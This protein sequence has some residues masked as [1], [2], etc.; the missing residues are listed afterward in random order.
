MV[1]CGSPGTDLVISRSFFLLSHDDEGEAEG[2]WAGSIDCA[3]TAFRPAS[4]HASPV[5]NGAPICRFVGLGTPTAGPHTYL[6]WRIDAG[7]H[8]GA[9]ALLFSLAVTLSRSKWLCSF[10][11][12]SLR[13]A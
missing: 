12:C 3:T 8:R 9:S 11:Q 7:A 1:L 2:A 13:T 6:A 4:K 5:R 10:A